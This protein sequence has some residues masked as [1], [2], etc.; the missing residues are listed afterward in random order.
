MLKCYLLRDLLHLLHLNNKFRHIL[1]H[2]II[3]SFAIT[4]KTHTIHSVE[5][6]FLKINGGVNYTINY[7]LRP[8]NAVIPIIKIKLNK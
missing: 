6:F 5:N 3:F 2:I 7:W 1:L 4:E 8:C